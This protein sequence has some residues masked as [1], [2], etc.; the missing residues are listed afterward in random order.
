MIPIPMDMI[1]LNGTYMYVHGRRRPRGVGITAWSPPRGVAGPPGR[2][3][4]DTWYTHVYTR[5]C[6]YK[7]ECNIHTCIVCKYMH[8]I[9]IYMHVCTTTCLQLYFW[10]Y[11][12]NCGNLAVYIIQAQQVISCI[13][14][15]RK[16]P[17]TVSQYIPECTLYILCVYRVYRVHLTI[18]HTNSL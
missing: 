14:I 12:A 1:L 10:Q 16:A 4:R 11:P 2:N 5:T 6:T 17:F 8:I 15:H 13:Q 3:T 18:S 7:H 9:S